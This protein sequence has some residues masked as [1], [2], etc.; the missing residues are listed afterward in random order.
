MCTH[1]H[2][3]THMHSHTHT[4]THTHTQ[5]NTH[6][7]SHT[8]THL[9]PCPPLPSPPQIGL[10]AEHSWADAPIV[11][12]MMEYCSSVEWADGT[13][14]NEQAAGTVEEGIPPPTRLQWAIPPEVHTPTT[15]QSC[16]ICA[17]SHG[18]VVSFKIHTIV[19]LLFPPLPSP[20]SLLPHH[21]L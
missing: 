17:S 4:H 11:G 5:T 13:Y 15:L 2:T 18:A 21:T 12:Y 9:S 1:T 19:P 20:P 6:M 3:Q 14:V 10:N 8:H 7:H 16:S